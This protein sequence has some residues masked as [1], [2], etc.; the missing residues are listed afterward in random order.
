MLISFA[1]AFSLRGGAISISDGKLS[2]SEIKHL[3]PPAKKCR[4]E[5]N[6]RWILIYFWFY[7]LLFMRTRN[8]DQTPPSIERHV[9]ARFL[10]LF[11]EHP[12][13]CSFW[14]N[15]LFSEAVG[16]LSVTHLWQGNPRL[17]GVAWESSWWFMDSE[18]ECPLSSC[19]KFSLHICPLFREISEKLCIKRSFRVS[20]RFSWSN[21]KQGRERFVNWLKCKLRQSK[22]MIWWEKRWHVLLWRTGHFQCCMS[23]DSLDAGRRLEKPYEPLA[24]LIK[25]F[26][27]GLA[28]HLIT[29]EQLFL[30]AGI[31][32]PQ[33]LQAH[34]LQ[35]ERFGIWKCQKGASHHKSHQK[36]LKFDKCLESTY[37][38]TPK[39]QYQNAALKALNS[40]DA[41]NLT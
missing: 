33:L 27:T 9:L 38:F 29:P 15:L 41:P 21:D 4:K 30:R 8:A 28:C 23:V 36:A 5:V 13:P 17:A 35:G 6:T 37:M 18:D 26:L 14:A 39:F 7:S 16:N 10:L 24:S 31:N 22:G 32:S 34:F 20:W 3:S 1:D 40:Y 25:M 12:S 11:G 2:P 19:L